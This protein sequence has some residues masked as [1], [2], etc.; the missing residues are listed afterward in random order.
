[1]CTSLPCKSRADALGRFLYIH[2]QFFFMKPL[3][4]NLF[5]LVLSVVVCIYSVY[6]LTPRYQPSLNEPANSFSALRAREHYRVVSAMPHLTGTPAN[7]LVRD[8]IIAWCDSMQLQVAVDTS[9]GLR[10]F[11]NITLGAV[12]H[13]IRAR[14]RGID[15]GKAIYVVAHYDSAP[16][17]YGAGDDGIAVIAMMECM[18]ALKA[19]GKRFKNDI[20]FYFTDAEEAG[21]LGASAAMR[22]S[23]IR[24]DMTLVFN[25][26]GTAVRGTSMLLQASPSVRPLLERY[27]RLP[28]PFGTSV[29]AEGKK[30]APGHLDFEI[31]KEADIPGFSTVLSEGRSHYHSL[32]D[33][34]ETINTKTIQQHGENML[35]LIH[36][37]GDADL[38]KLDGEKVGYFPVLSSLF[39]YPASWHL[40][41]LLLCNGLFIASMVVMLKEERSVGNEAPW[42]SFGWSVARFLLVL[43]FSFAVAYGLLALIQKAYPV[44]ARFQNF[45]SY[46]AWL[47]YIALGCS[48]LT[49]FGGVYAYGK[50]T[51][52]VPAALAGFHAIVL[53]VTDVVYT[54]EPDALYP[55]LFPLFF[56]LLAALVRWRR[57][58]EDSET[59]GRA[60]IAWLGALPAVLLLPTVI[61]F[62]YAGAFGLSEYAAVLSVPVVVL[63]GFL[64]PFWKEVDYKLPY[65]LPGLSFMGVLICFL[66]AHLGGNYSSRYPLRSSL[67]YRYDIDKNKASWLSDIGETDRWNRM[68]LGNAK[69]GQYTDSTILFTRTELADRLQAAADTIDVLP[70]DMRLASDSIADGNR[71]LQLVFKSNRQATLLRIAFGSGTVVKDM[72]INGIPVKDAGIDT[73][74]RIQFCGLDTDSLRVGIRV[75]AGVPLPVTLIDYTRGLPEQLEKVIRP[76]D[77]VPVAGWNANST[78]LMRRQT[79]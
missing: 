35:A 22:D 39:V 5:F 27:K 67:Y 34:P 62:S 43:L 48:A 72:T 3:W 51:F 4:R 31:F 9:I 28:H 59:A 24:R 56:S 77:I 41:L 61:Y 53:L 52:S 55:L 15:S 78:Q 37:F 57:E 73:A 2:F 33:R 23:S 76:D 58:G 20:V 64:L 63:A 29:S 8:S 16:N 30:Y 7:A 70:P 47:Y 65:W 32:I 26:D 54:R 17:S 25:Y 68:Y 6:I 74:R 46:N 14:L 44:L 21:L 36:E 18:R 11:Y 19:S 66:F 71:Y 69:R 75:K 79:F 45:E 13:N 12:T 10:S 60:V 50:R 49:V 40:W 38:G 42:A 1:M